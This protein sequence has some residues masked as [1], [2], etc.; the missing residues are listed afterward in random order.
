[1]TIIDLHPLRAE[2]FE[3]SLH[4]LEKKRQHWTSDKSSEKGIVAIEQK[5]GEKT[6]MF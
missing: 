2:E 3:S 1:M 4:N 5:S 6:E